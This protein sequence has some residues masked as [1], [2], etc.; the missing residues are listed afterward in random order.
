MA[1]LS[2]DELIK[3]VSD[4]VG[5]DDGALE[6]LGDLTDTLEDSTDVSGYEARI[7]ELEN[8]VAETETMWREKYK[9]RFTDVTPKATEDIKDEVDNGDNSE[10]G[11]IE[12]PSFEEIGNMFVK[13]ED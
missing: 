9:A 7:V 12:P 13:T 3:K 1:K 6:L 10:E 4:Y 5:N 2:K 8:K 11:D